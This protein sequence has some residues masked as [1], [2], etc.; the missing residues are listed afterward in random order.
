MKILFCDDSP[1]D[2]RRW[3]K[4]LTEVWQQLRAEHVLGEELEL[5]TCADITEAVGAPDSRTYT[6][7]AGF[8]GIL[9]DIL[10]KTQD[11]E[12]DEP[13]GLEIA[14]E[15]HKR[16]PE[17]PLIAFTVS[18]DPR[19]FHRLVHAGICGYLRKGEG[20]PA[21][22]FQIMECMDRH[23]KARGGQC[24]YKQLREL[25]SPGKGWAA[26]SVGDAATEV[27]NLDRS[28]DRWDAFWNAFQAPIA[29]QRLT[30]VFSKMRV[31]FGGA[32]L[33]M[34]GTLP[35]MRGHLDHVLNVYFTG[36][37]I[38]NKVPQFRMAAAAAAKRLFPDKQADVDADECRYWEMFQLAWL[39]AATLHDTAYPLEIQ[40]DL[41]RKCWDVRAPFADVLSDIGESPSL[42]CP[43]LSSSGLHELGVV[44]GRLYGR[45]DLSELVSECGKF[46]LNGVDRVNHGVAGGLLLLALARDAMAV[47]DAD[48]DLELYLKWA[49]AAIALH[50]LKKPG[51][52]MG[53][54]IS[55]ERDPLSY[56]L[57]A[58]DEI[59]VWDRERPDASRMSSPF[60]GTDLSSLSITDDS[61]TACVDYALHNGPAADVEFTSRREQMDKDIE[62]DGQE[63]SRYLRGE[64]FSVTV[65]RRVPSRKTSLAPLHF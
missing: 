56:L 55:L 8:D 11:A 43:G 19:Y 62:A 44:L 40:P 45:G 6:D 1:D 10:W 17:K 37:V 28:H 23:R 18:T 47:K 13:R 48:P 58:C 21:L 7:V 3:C 15:L 51:S 57:L 49:A 61:V 34:L 60:K 64:G 30:A 46:T 2:R 39:A 35:G 16:Y 38:S 9:L 65:N 29:S 4:N 33:L 50:S 63:L 14:E 31:F 5:Q 26:E 32:D 41:L 27:W 22:C 36:Y 42:S 25:T 24:L 53:V 52:E 12:C 54:S 20:Y 59:Q